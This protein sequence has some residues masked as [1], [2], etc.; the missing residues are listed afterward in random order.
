MRVGDL[1]T[2]DEAFL[3]GTAAEIVPLRELDGKPL[4]MGSRGPVTALL[5]AAY[6]RVTSG[7]DARHEKWLEFAVNDERFDLATIA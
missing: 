2:A 1:L 7:Q 5:Q 3:T 4:G 6:Q